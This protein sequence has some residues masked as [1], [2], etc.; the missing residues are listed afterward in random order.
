MKDFFRIFVSILGYGLIIGGFMVFGDSMPEDIKYLDMVVC[1]LLFTQLPLLFFIPLINLKDR[2]HKEVGSL[3]I[4]MYGFTFYSLAA[5]ATMVLG[6][7]FTWSFK[8]QLFVHIGILFF[9][10][11]M[12]LTS[13]FASSKVKQ[14]YHAEES[15]LRDRA[16]LKMKMAE[17]M[18]EV[19]VAGDRIPQSIRQPIEALN[20]TMRYLVP[21]SNVEASVLEDKFCSMVDELMVLLRNIDLNKDLIAEKLI[22]LELTLNKRKNY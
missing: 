19:T 9:F 5:I 4:Q 1:C 17:L 13:L 6:Y 10:C 20:E 7:I 2:S 18:D 22:R 16:I 8:V 15:K 12:I 21:S 3:G 14:R 11:L